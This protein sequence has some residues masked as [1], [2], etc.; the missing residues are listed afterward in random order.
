[1]S[2]ALIETYRTFDIYF[3]SGSEVFY[4]MSDRW[5]HETEGKSFSSVKKYIDDYIKDNSEF[6]PCYVQHRTNG[7]KIKLIGIRKDGR[8]VKEGEDGKK[9]QLSEYEEKYYTLVI[10]DNEIIFEN[11]KN[12][13]N[14]FDELRI[15]LRAE[16]AKVIIKDLKEI[17]DKYLI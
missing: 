17:R 3:D 5:D 6:K 14:Q 7:N 1:M 9:V 8:F 2:R 16:E 13:N 12:I 4:T 15:K 10:P 11:I